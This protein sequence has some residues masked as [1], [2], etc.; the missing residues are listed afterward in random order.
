[1]KSILLMCLIL[2]LFC[3]ANGYS[4]ALYSVKFDGC[5]TDQFTM[6]RDTTVAKISHE[7]LIEAVISNFDQKTLNKIKGVL[8]LQIIVDAAGNSCL[9]SMDNKTNIST[10]KL[11]VKE[12]LDTSS[13][14]VHPLKK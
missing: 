2:I 3:T 6:E 9:I 8:A 10:K 4:Q 1:M 5:Q 12:V 7:A 13:S 14:G 11:Q